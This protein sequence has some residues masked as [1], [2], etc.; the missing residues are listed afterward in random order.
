MVWRVA[1]GGSVSV[2][3]GDNGPGEDLLDVGYARDI[4]DVER[5]ILRNSENED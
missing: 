1:Q 3:I 5:A 4:E 2:D